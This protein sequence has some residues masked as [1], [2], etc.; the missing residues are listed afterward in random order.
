MCKSHQAPAENVNAICDTKE[1]VGLT[2]TAFKITYFRADNNQIIILMA[3]NL[4][5]P[6]AEDIPRDYFRPN[7]KVSYI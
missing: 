1:Y 5:F 3:K 7:V 2:L 4:H 6:N